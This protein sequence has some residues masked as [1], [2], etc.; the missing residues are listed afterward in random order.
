MDDGL[1][2]FERRSANPP[3]DRRAP[4]NPSDD[5]RDESRRGG[6]D[7]ARPTRARFHFAA[8]L[9][10]AVREREGGFYE[11]GRK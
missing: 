9:R 1:I 2:D 5:P 8:G 4:A 10:A 3:R 7:R 6:I 11:R